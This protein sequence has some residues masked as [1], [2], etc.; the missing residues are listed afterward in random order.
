MEFHQHPTQNYAQSAGQQNSTP[1]HHFVQQA[2]ATGFPIAS[3]NH[4][5]PPQTYMQHAGQPNSAPPHYVNPQQDGQV[6]WSTGLYDCFSDVPNCCITFW[7]P[8]I[9]FG[10]IA[11]RVDHGS[12]LCEACA[13]IYLVIRMFTR[14]HCIFSWFYRSRMRSR[15]MLEES[16][17]NDLCVHLWCENCALC[18]EYRELKNN[19]FHMYH[20]WHGNT[21]GQQ[22]HGMPMQPAPVMES[23]M[24][25]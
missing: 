11:H 17:C 10:Q 1:P 20:G 24:K 23:G 8:C 14:F 5:Y 12:V 3:T 15:Y 7:F 25:R 4:Q 16:P 22:N 6:P 9:T 13:A 19:G 18:Q 21:T 2:P